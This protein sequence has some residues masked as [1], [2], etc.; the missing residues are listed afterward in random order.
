MSE[1]P[2]NI[3]YLGIGS[4]LGNRKINIEN[5]YF[6]IINFANILSSHTIQFVD[7]NWFHHTVLNEC[8]WESWGDSE[9]A[10][11]RRLYSDYM[12]AVAFIAQ[13]SSSLV[14]LSIMQLPIL[15]YEFK[16]YFGQIMSYS[17]S[18][19]ALLSCLGHK[20]MRRPAF[21]CAISFAFV[22]YL[23]SCLY[24]FLRRSFIR[25]QKFLS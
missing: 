23:Y 6:T 15:F 3:V 19:S 14:A 21:W 4:N 8:H 18:D 20:L 16:V 2:V 25:L 24:S 22:Y 12:N 9:I 5:A 17:M 10:Q 13:R 1:N 7:K 11:N